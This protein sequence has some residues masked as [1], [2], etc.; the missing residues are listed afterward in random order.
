MTHLYTVHMKTQTVGDLLRHARETAQYSLQDLSI[1]T[2]IKL[3]YLEALEDNDFDA[4]P[5]ATFVKAYIR[6]YARVFDL[7]QKP[8][9]AMLRRDY[10]ESVK[11][12]LIRRDLLA[13]RLARKTFYSPV[14]L[15]FVAAISIF[16]VFFAYAG[17]QWYVLTRPPLIVVQAPVVDEVVA[18]QVIVEGRT[19]PDASLTINTMPVALQPDGSFRS[20]LYLPQEGPATITLRAT[21][22]NGRSTVLQRSVRVAF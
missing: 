5:A 20:E 2:H 19:K 3:E 15:I 1:E 6:N 13:P 4:L 14:Q 16:A 18:A 10:E 21:D 22:K 7:D 11:G 9:L 17:W 12:Q 8:L